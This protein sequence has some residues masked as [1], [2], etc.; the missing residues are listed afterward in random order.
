[1]PSC[2]GTS[3][4]VVRRKHVLEWRRAVTGLC[5]PAS[6]ETGQTP[7]DGAMTAK[8]RT[9]SMTEMTETLTHCAQ[10]SFD[11]SSRPSWNAASIRAALTRALAT[12]L[13]HCHL[14]ADSEVL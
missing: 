8:Q 3:E 9:C 12:Q 11:K 4:Q 14:N 10:E 7:A 13:R 5:H 1:M 2:L 6:N